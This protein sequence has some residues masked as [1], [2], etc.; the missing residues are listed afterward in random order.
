MYSAYAWQRAYAN[1]RFE[2]GRDT[3][4]TLP[5]WEVLKQE[6]QSFNM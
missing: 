4:W 6:L 2:A 1:T 5:D 3:V